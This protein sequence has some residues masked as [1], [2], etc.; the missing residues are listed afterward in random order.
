MQ[1][2]RG[3]A[4]LT[5]EQRKE[6]YSAATDFGFQTPSFQEF[7]HQLADFFNEATDSLKSSIIN[8]SA[9]VDLGQAPHRA[10][11]TEVL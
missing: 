10:D 9:S 1:L 7:A 2:L 4:R 3:G 8:N 5:P 6:V 11:N